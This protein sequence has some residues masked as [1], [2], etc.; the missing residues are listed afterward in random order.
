VKVPFNSRDIPILFPQIKPKAI[1]C[2]LEIKDHIPL[3]FKP[4]GNYKANFHFWPKIFSGAYCK[5]IL[6]RARKR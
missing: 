4:L 2:P 5:S 6:K 1:P 3:L